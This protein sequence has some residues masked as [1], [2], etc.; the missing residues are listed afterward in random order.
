MNMNTYT[1]VK[2]DQQLSYSALMLVSLP[3]HLHR[4]GIDNVNEEVAA[5]PSVGQQANSTIINT[6]TSAQ[7]CF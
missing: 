6:V 1:Y 3:N 4:M 5:S 7:S 2:T